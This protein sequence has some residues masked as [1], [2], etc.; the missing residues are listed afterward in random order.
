TATLTDPGN[1]LSLKTLTDTV[2]VNGQAYR[3]IF[4]AA[5]HTITNTSPAGRQE[6]TTL[7][8]LG[9]VV[10]DQGTGLDPLAYGYDGRGRLPCVT[11]GGRGW[12]CGDSGDNRGSR[13]TDALGSVVRFTYDDA[14]RVT[15]A[16]RPD[17]EVLT[18][19][20]DAAGNLTALTPPGRPAHT[21]S[22]TPTNQVA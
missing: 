13:L 2:A 8:A 11:E 12:T 1:L 17:G 22:Y 5:V 19:A 4:D 16:I 21:F 18:A 3:G 6:V 7:D 14:G 9:R 20:Y 15:Q 10:R